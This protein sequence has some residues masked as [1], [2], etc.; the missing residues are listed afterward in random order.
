VKT[1]FDQ[2]RKWESEISGATGAWR[3]DHVGRIAE[4]RASLDGYE[5]FIAHFAG[6][7]PTSPVTDKAWPSLYD[8]CS[9]LGKAVDYRTVH[10]AMCSQVHHDAEDI[11]NAFM[12]GSSSNYEAR[13]QNL[14]RETGNFSIF[15]LLCSLRYYLECLGQLSTRYRMPTV[16][17]QA[18]KS[19]DAIEAVTAAVTADGFVNSSFDAFLPRQT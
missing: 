12:I 3:A 19:F 8:I 16:L 4:K 17:T 2:T 11:L 18:S 7:L 9:A 15:L 1:E 5:A 6:T 10:M 13:A 14:E